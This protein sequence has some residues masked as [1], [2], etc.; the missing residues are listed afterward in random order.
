MANSLHFVQPAGRAGVVASLADHL[1]VGGAFVVVEYDADHGNP[2]VP[3]PFRFDTWVRVAG[4]AGLVAPRPLEHV[5]SRFLGGIYSA[6]AFR[7]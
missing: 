5:P 2:W 7:G 4:T 3:H 1:R 6:V